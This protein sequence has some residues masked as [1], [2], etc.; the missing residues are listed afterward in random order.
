MPNAGSTWE[1]LQRQHVQIL[2]D[3]FSTLPNDLARAVQACQQ[4]AQEHHL[5]KD[6]SVTALQIL[7]PTSGKGAN[8]TKA[9]ELLRSIGNLDSF[10]L[11]ELLKFV[12]FLDITAPYIIQ[13]SKDRKTYI[14]QP[15]NAELTALKR[16]MREFRAVCWSSTAVKLDVLTALRF[17]LAYV[18]HRERVLQGEA[19]GR[20]FRA[21][22]TL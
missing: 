4:L 7:N 14:L 11:F 16:I 3:L 18:H 9:R 6:V 15:Q 21:G 1:R 10:W 12:G 20:S 22:A 19:Q 5:K 17:T 13:G 8:A 2:L